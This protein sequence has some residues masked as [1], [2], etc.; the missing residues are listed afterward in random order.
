MARI[1]SRVAFPQRPS[2][3]TPAH[4]TGSFAEL[5][6]IWFIRGRHSGIRLHWTFDR[7]IFK[8]L[9]VLGFP[10]FLITVAG[11]QNLNYRYWHE[12]KRD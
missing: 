5:V 8:R 7:D 11:W 6:L 1:T 4:Q 12:S 2:V 9:I 3:K 10:M